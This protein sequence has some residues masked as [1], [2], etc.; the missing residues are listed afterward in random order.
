M[1]ARLAWPGCGRPSTPPGGDR[2][3]DS[4]GRLC[5]GPPPHRGRRRGRA[6][7]VRPRHGGRP[8]HGGRRGAER[9]G[10]NG[11]NAGRDA[12]GPA[13]AARDRGAFRIPGDPWPGRVVSGRVVSGCESHRVCDEA[14]PVCDQFPAALPTR[15][16][17]ASPLLNL[18]IS[19]SDRPRR[20]PDLRSTGDKHQKP[21]SRTERRRCAR[22]SATVPG[23]HRDLAAPHAGSHSRRR[24]PAVRQGDAL[25]EVPCGHHAGAGQQPADPRC[26]AR[27]LGARRVRAAGDDRPPYRAGAAYPGGKRAG[28]RYLLAGRRAWD[29]KRLR[30]EPA[31]R[32]PGCESRPTASGVPGRLSWSQAMTPPSGR[33][34]CRTA[35][36]RRPGHRHCRHPTGQ[37]ARAKRP[38]RRR[39]WRCRS[40]P[41][42]PARRRLQSLVAAMRNTRYGG[43]RPLRCIRG[44]VASD[45]RPGRTRGCTPPIAGR[46]ASRSSGAQVRRW[47]SRHGGGFPAGQ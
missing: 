13:A 14:R 25:A 40:V 15:T 26:R 11:G 5:R 16:R 3:R 6:A 34:R 7:G 21:S 38:C 45:H 31:G 27:G 24:G 37:P 29:A 12:G 30:S 39:T 36:T 33:G 1:H 43:R 18:G 2:L 8:G 44:G 4:P 41:V 20:T 17:K 32:N 10:R 35:G 47:D 23:T 22:P 28:P 9:S 42:C 46:G 19:C